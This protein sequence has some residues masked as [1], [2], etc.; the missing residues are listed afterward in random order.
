MGVQKLDCKSVVTG[1]PL[2]H[3]AGVDISVSLDATV[4]RLAKNGT[5]LVGGVIFL[6]SKADE[7]SAKARAE[8]CRVS[9]VLAYLFAKE[10]L[11]YAGTADPKLCYSFDVMAGKA[12]QAPAA[13]KTLIDHMHDSCEEVVLRW[14]EM[15]P[16]DDYDGPAWK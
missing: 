9:A 4:H 2:L 1:Q 16:P 14:K 15:A 8:R 6:L 10:H 12:T 13:H 3:I 11:A 7:A 5:N